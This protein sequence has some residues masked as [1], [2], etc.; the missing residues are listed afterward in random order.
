MTN[1]VVSGPR[2]TPPGSRVRN[3]RRPRRRRRGFP[4]CVSARPDDAVEVAAAL[5]PVELLELEPQ[6]PTNRPMPPAPPAR[7]ICLRFEPLL[8]LFGRDLRRRARLTDVVCR[9]SVHLSLLLL[10]RCWFGRVLACDSLV[11]PAVQRDVAFRGQDVSLPADPSSSPGL[12][13]MRAGTTRAKARLVLLAPVPWRRTVTSRI[14]A[15]MMI[16]PS[17]TVL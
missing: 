8:S 5:E 11:L 17:K 3:H 7:S 15:T 16:A 13:R 6:A 14:P 1:R 2:G 12:E 10:P 9:L 4:S